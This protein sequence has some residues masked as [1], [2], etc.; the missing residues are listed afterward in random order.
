MIHAISKEGLVTEISNGEHVIY[1]DATKD[2]GGNDEFMRPGDL[3]ASAY[4][5]C[6]SITA[7]RL[8]KERG[9]VYKQVVVSVDLDRSNPDKTKF[10]SSIVIEGDIPDKEKTDIIQAAKDCAVCQVLRGEKEFLD[11]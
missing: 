11:L 9:F 7:R 10:L 8:L 5:G 4:A 3:L 1:A 6:M 2:R